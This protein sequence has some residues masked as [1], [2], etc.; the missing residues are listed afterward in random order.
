M[1]HFEANVMR[2]VCE[3]HNT[4]CKYKIADY[5]KF[6]QNWSN[7]D[8]TFTF[9]Y[10]IHS[11]LNKTQI[12]VLTC[13]YQDE[14]SISETADKL[15]LEENTV[16]IILDVAIEKLASIVTFKRLYIGQKEFEE[17]ITNKQHEFNHILYNH[18][19]DLL[20][21]DIGLNH[22]AI[23]ILYRYLETYKNVTA[24]MALAKIPNLLYVPGCSY[25]TAA[26]II[27]TF[28]Q[29]NIDCTKWIDALD[30][31]SDE[32][33]MLLTKYGLDLDRKRVELN[34]HRTQ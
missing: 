22:R 17:L 4:K 29:N 33:D 3:C 14:L 34:V 31:K 13:I 7:R 16:Q 18:N 12:N 27:Y 9:N 6:R 19:K 21:S 28:K 8:F 15:I 26:H 25:A 24:G 2:K 30:I 10:V 32:L 5:F 11:V 1:T 23:K 20:I